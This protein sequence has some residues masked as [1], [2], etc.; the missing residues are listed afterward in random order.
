MADTYSLSLIGEMDNL[1]FHQI[2]LFSQPTTTPFVAKHV[3]KHVP[4]SESSSSSSSSSS[5]LSLTPLLDEETSAD[6]TL[7]SPKQVS[8]ISLP[9]QVHIIY[10]KKI[11]STITYEVMIMFFLFCFV[12][13]VFLLLQGWFN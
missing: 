5:I 6:Q 3:E 1:W 7:S 2:I 11:L 8:I 12:Y 4:I 10:I 9:V 13:F